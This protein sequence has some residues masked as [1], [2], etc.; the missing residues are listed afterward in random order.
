M[1]TFAVKAELIFLK[2]GVA[3]IFP[4]DIFGFIEKGF[5]LGLILKAGV[6]VFAVGIALGLDEENKGVYLAFVGCISC[7][8]CR[9]EWCKRKKKE[10]VFTGL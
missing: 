10:K 9:G 8:E 6:Y 7:V 3:E 5:P 4:K 1:V 2:F